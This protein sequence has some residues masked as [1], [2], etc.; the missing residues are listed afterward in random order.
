VEELVDLAGYCGLARGAAL[1]IVAEAEKATSSWA[2]VAAAFGIEPDEITYMGSAFESAN[3][4][5]AR[6]LVAAADMDMSGMDLTPGRSG[7]VAPHVRNGRQVR[8]YRRTT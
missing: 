5:A 4:Q 8:G 2:C 6:R 7:W 1:T 3:R